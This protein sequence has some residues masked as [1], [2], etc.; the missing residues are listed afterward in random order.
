MNKPAII[1]TVIGAAFLSSCANKTY[2]ID[3]GAYPV[4]P[5]TSTSKTLRAMG[6]TNPKFR[7]KAFYGN[8]GGPGNNGGAPIDAMDKLFYEHDRAYI[9]C[10]KLSELRDA[11]EALINGLEAL[12]ENTL[13]EHAIDYRDRATGFFLKPLSQFIGKPRDVRLGIRSEKRAFPIEEYP[14]PKRG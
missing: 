8:Y 1:L 3:Y 11:D 9:E 5:I 2:Y 13:S 10:V 14:G 6:R 4:L 12:D 7:K